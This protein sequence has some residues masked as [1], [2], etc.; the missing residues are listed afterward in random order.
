MA[1]ITQWIRQLSEGSEASRE[2]AASALHRQ[3][4]ALGDSAI[5]RWREDAECRDMLGAA[6]VGIAVQPEQF[7][8]IRAACGS[9]QL[10]NVPP[11]QDAMEF[12]LHF[13]TSVHLDILTTK[14]P[15]GGGAI[16]KFLQKFGEGIQQI[17]YLVPDVDR[18]TE[19]LRE[20]FSVKPIYPQTRIGADD[21][22][23]NFFLV[24]TPDGK[25]VLIELVEKN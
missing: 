11:D 22:R 2:L 12:E 16:D 20:R 15:G 7:A 17:E 8:K 13:G 1:D 25:R 10:A 9:P 18:A 3:G 6:T 21:T 5:S 23:V 19:L 14:A 4:I 24:P